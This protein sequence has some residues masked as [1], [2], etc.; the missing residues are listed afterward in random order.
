[1][2][3]SFVTQL[4]TKHTALSLLLCAVLLNSCGDAVITDDYIAQNIISSLLIVNDTV[5]GVKVF[6]SQP[7]NKPYDVAG[8]MIKDA[9]VTL[10]EQPSNVRIPLTYRTTD[11]LGNGEYYSAQG[12]IVKRNTKYDLEVKFADGTSANGTTTTPDSIYWKRTPASISQF[13]IDSLRQPSTDTLFWETNSTSQFEY[14]LSI[15]TLDTLEY[16][17]YLT[18]PT[19]EKNRRTSSLINRFADPGTNDYFEQTNWAFLVN[20]NAPYVWAV[21]KW[22]GKH[23]IVLY[24]PDQNMS[25]WFKLN[26][27]QGNEKNYDPN[28]GSIKGNAI[29]VC[30]SAFTISADVFILKNQP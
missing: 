9:V 8:S 19:Q 10:I 30:G 17:K 15:T 27:F 25:K 14:L 1:M 3:I 4:F 23:K 28:Q 21:F 18:P 6:R 12:V 20:N 11:T 24:S 13:P 26:Q 29:G 7:L 22:F 2:S 5:K 16:G